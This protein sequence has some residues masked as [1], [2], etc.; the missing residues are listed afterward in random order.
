MI[1]YQFDRCATSIYEEIKTHDFI[2]SVALV[3]FWRDNILSKVCASKV[4]FI[5]A[6][7]NPKI[8]LKFVIFGDCRP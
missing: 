2:F 5:F 6:V 8:T 4:T 1:S 7:H 3:L